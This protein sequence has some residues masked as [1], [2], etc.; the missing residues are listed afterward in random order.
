MQKIHILDEATI[1]KIAAGEVIERPASVVKELIENSIDAEA[2]DIRIEVIQGG[3]K[4][5]RIIDN[6]CGMSKEDAALSFVKHSTSKIS[7]SEDIENVVTMGFRG[8]ALSSITA[9]AKVE[10]ITKTKDDMAGTKITVHG[11]K[12][13]S[14]SETGAADGTM[15]MVEDLFYNTPARKKYLKSDTTELA[16]ITDVVTKNALGHNDVSF[17]LLHNGNEILRSPASELRDTII[18]I[19]GQEVARAMVAVDFDSRFAKVTGF[20]SKPAVTRGGIDSQSFYINNRSVG[21]RALSF[22]LRDGYGTLIPK[23]RFPVAVLKIFIA[24][25]EVD[26][27]VHPTK[28]QVR[29]SHEREVSNAMSEAVKRAFS[30]ENLAPAVKIP[31]KQSLLYEQTPQSPAIIREEPVF[32]YPVKDTERRL[33]QTERYVIDELKIKS[34]EAPQV[35]ILGQVGSLYVVAKTTDGLV[36]I[37]Q[38]AAHER[39]L[40]EQVRES[41]RSDSQELIVPINIE[42]EPREK[43]LMKESIP[44]LEEFGF[45]ISGF[46]QDTFAVTAVPNILGKLEDPGLVH[47]IMADILSEGKI[48]DDTGI[49]ERITRSIACRGAIK[50]GADCSSDQMESL[51][52]QLFKTENPYTCPHGRPTMI[53]FNRQEL[54]KLFKRS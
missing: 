22:A 13:E 46:G 31:V 33:R 42:L 43:A 51:I 39:V 30:D 5:I 40:F 25:G 41:K 6:G 23:G 12:L 4:L 44:Y 29:L 24:T 10:I 7:R 1:N 45:R 2:S 19:Y 48:K 20:V 21:S 53:S 26:V 9:V 17:T 34:D 50:A 15:I 18:H 37:D 52:K 16:H 14:I 47:D 8:E 36:I 11:G 32:K 54:D 27:N 28:N 49:F 38:H 35:K 3:K